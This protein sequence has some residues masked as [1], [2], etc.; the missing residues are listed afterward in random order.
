MYIA[1]R[2]KQENIA[3]Y[4]LYMWQVEDILRAHHLDADELRRDYLA[5]FRAGADAE[6]EI[7]QWYADLIRMMREE[8]VQQAG[9]LQ[10]N[11]N[12]IVLLSDLHRELMRSDKHPAY[13]AAYYKALPHI[14]ELRAKNGHKEQPELETCFEA[15]YG[16]MML[17]LQQKAVSEGTAAAM[18]DISKMMGML[19]AYYKE[20]QEGTLE[21]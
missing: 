5:Q 19:S 2:L 16:M 10:I 20:E 17:R 4:L 6:K 13:K 15:L 1:Q 11:R 18:A 3:E 14:V 9:H 12:I 8:G 21:L 7:E